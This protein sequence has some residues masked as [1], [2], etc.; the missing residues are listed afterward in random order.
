LPASSPDRSFWHR[1]GSIPA[2]LDYLHG[3][4]WEFVDG[5]E[6]PWP[7]SLARG[8]HAWEQIAT[9]VLTGLLV[10]VLAISLRDALP[11]RR[12]STLAAAL[13]GILG[14]ALTTAAFRVDVPMLSGGDPETWN[15][16]AHGIAFLSIIATGLLAPLAMAVALRG[17]A[18]WRPIAAVSLAA[19][20]LFVVFLVLPWGNAT[21]LLAV[22]ILFAWIAAVAARLRSF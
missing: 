8:P 18:S 4:G 3:L 10:L 20:V 13:L 6:V 7:S 15:G 17:D 9:F 2:S 12:A 11:R 16:W 5:E 21:F 14:A 22:V 19:A 1:S